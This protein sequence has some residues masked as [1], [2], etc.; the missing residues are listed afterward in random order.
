LEKY[1]AIFLCSVDYLHF[2]SDKI[3]GIN[4]ASILNPAHRFLKVEDWYT[5]TKRTIK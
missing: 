4:P 1:P 5:K 3:L 2:A